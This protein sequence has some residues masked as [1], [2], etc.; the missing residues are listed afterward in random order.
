MHAS[1]LPLSTLLRPTSAASP[2][3]DTVWVLL[4]SSSI[5]NIAFLCV[6]AFSC[7]W[8][9]R[10]YGGSQRQCRD[11]WWRTRLLLRVALMQYLCW[12]SAII[13][14]VSL[15]C[16]SLL[17]LP[18]ELPSSEQRPICC[19]ACLRRVLYSVTLNF[20]AV[21]SSTKSRCAVAPITIS[22]PKLQ[23]GSCDLVLL[24]N[25]RALQRDSARAKP[26]KQGA[27]AAT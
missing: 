1:F 22:L 11:A 23:T 5:D 27:P 8:F 4:S 26:K 17:I 6:L 10:W 20:G 24:G 2:P 13:P 3:Q 19:F 12:G 25:R 21:V 14:L 7:R 18:F 16:S 9:C 15:F